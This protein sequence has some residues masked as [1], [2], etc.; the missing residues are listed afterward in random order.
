MTIYVEYV[1]IDNMA[2]N[3]LLLFLTK[4]LLKLKTNKWRIVLS[5]TLGT[6]V[7]LLSPLLPN[8]VNLL[9]KLPLAILMLILAFELKTF[10]KLSITFLTFLS[11]TFVFGGAV[12]GFMEILG[13]NFSTKNGIVYEYKIPIGFV[14]CV[15]G[16]MF[17]CI[18]NIAKYVANKNINSKLTYKANIEFNGNKVSVIAFLDSGNKILVDGKPVCIINFKTFNAL[19][20]NIELADIL[21][22]NL[23]KLENFKYIEVASIGNSKQKLLSFDADFIE[24]D[25]KKTE[26]VKLA[27]SLINF[28]AKT[29]S[30]II[31]SN[32][33]LGEEY[34]TCKN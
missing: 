1:V 24:I 30:D 9:I 6:I 3:T 19:C 28:S 8:I 23:S 27:L 22:K 12:L 14:V 10:K 26:K 13:I 20:P 7:A 18:K 15:A 5:A 32:Q 4:Y 29:E 31:I 33:I 25:G 34:E 16:V 11:C 21:M 2:I 17:V